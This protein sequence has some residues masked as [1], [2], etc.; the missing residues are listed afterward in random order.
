MADHSTL[1]IDPWNAYDGSALAVQDVAVPVLRHRT[2]AIIGPSGCGKSTVL[3]CLNRMHQ[4]VPR[5]TGRVPLEG[6]NIYDSGVDPVRVRRRIGM[7]FQMELAN[8][9]F[10]QAVITHRVDVVRIVQDKWVMRISA[11]AL[12]STVAHQVAIAVERNVG[13]GSSRGGEHPILHCV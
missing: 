3:R 1:A 4:V 9:R 8:D 12:N 6:Q 5:G 13:F 11:T 10:G 2:T 7:R